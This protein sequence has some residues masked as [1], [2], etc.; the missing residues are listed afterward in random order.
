VEDLVE[1]S[2][3]I[4]VCLALAEGVNLFQ[5]FLTHMEGRGFRKESK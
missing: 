1:P 3:Q 5:G 4:V 2:Q